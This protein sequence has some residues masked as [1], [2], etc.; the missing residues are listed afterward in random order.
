MK[1]WILWTA[2]LYPRAWRE[3]YG[4]EFDALVED[5]GAGWRDL[6]D[7]GRGAVFMQLSSGRTLVYCALVGVALGAFAWGFMDPGYEARVLVA[8]A[9][10]RELVKERA[11]KALSRKALMGV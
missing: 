9:E 4:E 5:A 1:R 3:R 2:R 8:G 10:N 7:V 11:E 6:W